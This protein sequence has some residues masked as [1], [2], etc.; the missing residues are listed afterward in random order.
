MRSSLTRFAIAT[1]L[2]A[3]PAC[4]RTP[5]VTSVQDTEAGI[6]PSRLS[7]AFR[8]FDDVTATA[9]LTPLRTVHLKPGE[10]EVRVWI[11]GGF[12]YPQ[13][14]YRF[15]ERSGRVRGTLLRHW[16]TAA[17]G[18]T[19]GIHGETF[20]DLIRYDQSTRC[21]KFRTADRAG[22]CEASFT[23]TPNWKRVLRDAEGEGLW[24]LPDQS[25]LPNDRIAVF[26]GWGITVE[27]RDGDAYRAYEYDNPGSHPSWAR[28]ASHV[29]AIARI[30]QSV[31]ALVPSGAQSYRGITSGK[32]GSGFA[33]CGAKE[34]WRFDG[35]L[36]DY[37]KRHPADS[38][39]TA[40]DS[41]GR[42]EVVVTGH[43]SPEWLMTGWGKEFT[44]NLRVEA[45]T[46]V[47]STR[48]GGC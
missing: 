30:M 36:S 19:L 26:D 29:I 12:G 13:S 38:A 25:A 22:T 27:L 37:W 47:R 31:N 42:Y 10:R 16:P 41:S 20:D 9:G 1:A 3:A 5:V 43:L 18:D 28:Q 35:S 6:P 33:R 7:A 23:R 11:G 46:S 48:P 17:P 32:Y 21:T 39:R 44:R 2:L 40:R 4:H 34:A 15:V 45:I 8:E 24:T 14:L